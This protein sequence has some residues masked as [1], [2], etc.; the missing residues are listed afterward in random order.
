MAA[1]RP[2]VGVIADVAGSPEARARYAGDAAYVDATYRL[3]LGRPADGAGAAW[4]VDGIRSGRVPPAQFAA[5]LLASDEGLR[6]RAA[7]ALGLLDRAPDPAGVAFWAQQFGAGFDLDDLL[8][9]VAAS[10]E[11][12]LQAPDA[13]PGN[14]SNGLALLAGL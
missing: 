3:L 13:D 4:A 11:Y 12:R 9:Y 14:S 10:V 1:G 2:F 7:A 8:G 5:T 6:R